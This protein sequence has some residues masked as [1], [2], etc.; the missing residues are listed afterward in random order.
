ME[1]SATWTTCSLICIWLHVVCGI[2]PNLVYEWDTI[3]LVWPNSSF[4][5]DYIRTNKFI[6]ENNAVNGIK[7]YNNTIYLTIPKLKDGIPVSLLVID[8]GTLKS[9]SLRPFPSWAMHDDKDCTKLNLVQSMEIDPYTGYM[10][11]IDTAWVP[12]TNLSIADKCPSKIVIWDLNKNVEVHRHTFPSGVTGLGLFYLND[13]V[14]DFDESSARWA[15]ISDT[16]GHKLIVY[17]YK[18]D[19]SYAFSHPSMKPDPAYSQIT[20]GGVQNNYAPLGIN[21]IAMASDLKY[22]YY[23][24]LAGIGLYRIATTILRNGKSTDSDFDKGVFHVGDKKVQS[25]GLYYSQ[26]HDLYYSTLGLRSVFQWKMT[27]SCDT[28]KAGEQVEITKDDRIA[29]VDSFSFDDSGYLWF[30]SNNINSGP[31]ETV[32][33]QSEYFVWKIYVNDSSYLYFNFNN[34]NQTCCATKNFS[35]AVLILLTCF[36]VRFV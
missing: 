5:E 29:W 28:V 36:L 17:D 14:L 23:C 10:W 3:D 19:N 1:N 35:L 20:I 16:L 31:N 11:I 34:E 6:A 7:I 25:D 22:V 8:N 12:R 21:G 9:P 24:P 2:A 33:G 13:I 32:E 4:R 26:K 30:V 18:L 15:Y 27:P